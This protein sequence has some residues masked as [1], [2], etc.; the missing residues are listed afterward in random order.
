MRFPVQG[1]LWLASQ[2]IQAN[3]MELVAFGPA[4]PSRCII[5]S[6]FANG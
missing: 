6:R 4:Q 2:T 3:A 1:P 5:G